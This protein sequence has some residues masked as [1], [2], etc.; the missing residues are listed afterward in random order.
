MTDLDQAI[1]TQIRKTHR[2]AL[3]VV[4]K[5]DV[6]GD[7]IVHELQKLGIGTPIPIAAEGGLGIGDLLDAILMVTPSY[8]APPMPSAVI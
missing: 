1:A 5:V 8:S 7:T 3:L 2:H 4:N 6:A